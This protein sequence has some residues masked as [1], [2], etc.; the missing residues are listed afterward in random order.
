[1]RDSF[2]FASLKLNVLIIYYMASL[3][4]RRVPFNSG[5]HSFVIKD[6]L[7]G[8]PVKFLHLFLA[9]VSFSAR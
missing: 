3:R 5:Q 9:K 4:K 6:P 8:F 1:M 2:L 7:W